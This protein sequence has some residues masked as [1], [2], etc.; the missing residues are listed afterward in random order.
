MAI[1]GRLDHGHEKKLNVKTDGGRRYRLPL[2]LSCAR[3]QSFL[4]NIN[5]TWAPC[6]RPHLYL[7]QR[8]K[9]VSI[10]ITL[11]TQWPQTVSGAERSSFLNANDVYTCAYGSR[12]FRLWPP[13]LLMMLAGRPVRWGRGSGVGRTQLAGK[14][15]QPASVWGQLE[16]LLR[17]ACGHLLADWLPCHGSAGPSS[18]LI[19]ADM[20]NVLGWTDTVVIAGVGVCLCVRVRLLWQPGDDE[21]HLVYNMLCRLHQLLDQ[22]HKK[23]DLQIGKY[24]YFLRDS[25]FSLHA[26]LY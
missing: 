18:G 5:K 21:R 4:G 11:A 7:Y 17:G 8:G 19:R 6:K 26:Y 14:K 22:I 3:C 23:T 13:P 20:A 10:N 12:T 9:R 2:P 25:G 15:K 1:S 16:P 24:I